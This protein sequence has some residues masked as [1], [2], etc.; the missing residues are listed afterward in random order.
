MTKSGWL[1]DVVF[2]WGNLDTIEN[3]EKFQMN[4]CIDKH[5]H[6]VKLSF[7][8]RILSINSLLF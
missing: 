5:I 1:Y 8:R 4:A 6:K 7:Y 3:K 2:Y